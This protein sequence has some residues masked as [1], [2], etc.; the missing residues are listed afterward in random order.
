L[1]LTAVLL[2]VSLWFFQYALQQAK[3]RGLLTRAEMA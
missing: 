1:S 3:R 2:I